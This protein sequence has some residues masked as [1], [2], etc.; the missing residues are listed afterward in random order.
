MMAL[1]ADS[2]LMGPTSELGPID[3]Q[4]L[5]YN[6]AGQ[7]IWRPAQSYLDGLEQIRKSVA[8]EIKN[9]GNPQL[10]PTYYPLLSQLDP[11]L[12][13]WCA[14]A[15][16]RAAEFAEK[17]LSRH[18]LKEQPDVAKQ[19]AQRLVDA[20]KYQSHGMV[21][22]WKD[23]E[24]LGLKIVRLKE[25]ELFWQKIWRLYLAYDVK[26]RGAQIAKLFEGRKVSVGAS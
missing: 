3:P 23:A 10:N 7:P 15:L 5:T 14:K 18:M 13:D 8:E 26:C 1:G 6:S 24:E 19:V 20:R 21:I 16:N 2:I 12:L 22:N 11:A 25:E 4:V 17:W 9:T